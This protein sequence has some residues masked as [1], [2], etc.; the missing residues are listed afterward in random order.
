MVSPSADGFI[1][2]GRQDRMVKR[3]GHRI[4]LDELEHALARCPDVTGAAVIADT[5]QPS[6]IITAFVVTDG[7]P[8]T[9]IGLR[10][11]CRAELGPHLIPDRFVHL[12]ALPH[13]S[14]GKVDY[15]R[16]QQ[17]CS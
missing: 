7:A 16:L 14:T 13:T 17:T 1:F 8:V 9:Q 12:V 11:F 10:S 5:T 3:R 4:E 15:Q 2:C 6:A